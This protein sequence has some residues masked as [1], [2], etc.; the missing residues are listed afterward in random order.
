MMFITSELKF[1]ELMKHI[2]HDIEC[3]YSYFTGEVPSVNN[4]N[5]S[6]IYCSTCDED[7]I[8]IDN[9]SYYTEGILNYPHNPN[10]YIVPSD[11]A[12]TFTK[13]KGGSRAMI[14][15]RK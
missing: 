15:V 13:L 6:V 1:K 8:C 9:P 11:D 3:T 10:G 2:G 7:I 14:E 12:P 4:A 5:E